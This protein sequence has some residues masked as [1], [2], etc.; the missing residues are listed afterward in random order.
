MYAI[1]LIEFLVY[2]IN[3]LVHQRHFLMSIT[4]SS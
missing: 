4:Y 1:E 2:L 3:G